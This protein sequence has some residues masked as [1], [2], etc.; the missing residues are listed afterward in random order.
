MEPPPL[1]L[2][3]LLACR[4]VSRRPSLVLLISYSPAPG[5]SLLWNLLHG[6]SAEL[7]PMESP[8]LL[9]KLLLACKDVSRRPSLL[10]L[11]SYS[12]APGTSLLW[13]LLQGLSA[14]LAPME[15][16]PLLL[17]LLLAC[18]D[19][20]RRPSLLLLISYSP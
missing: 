1:L 11:I 16:P 4:D 2:K 17:K 5:T 14:E 20:S 3:L 18:K 15:P 19:V 9:L 8:P 12:P 13:N 6:L 7:T 10:L